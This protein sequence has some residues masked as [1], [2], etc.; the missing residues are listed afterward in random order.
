MPNG[1]QRILSSQS[2]D[3]NNYKLCLLGTNPQH[4]KNIIQKH[5]DFIKNGGIMKS[6]FV[7]T[8]HDICE[9]L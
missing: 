5:N 1:K 9:F 6:I 7:G 2:L 3:L 4:H 8:E